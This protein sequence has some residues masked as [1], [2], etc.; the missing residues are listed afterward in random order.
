VRADLADWS[1]TAA[2]AYREWAARRG[3]TLQILA[4]A[5]ETMGLMTEAA[6][7]LIGSVRLLVRDAVATVVSRLIVYAGE[8]IATAGLAT[9]LVVEQVVTLCAAWGARIARWLRA[10][11]ASL[12]KLGEA[13]T[14]LQ[15]AVRRLQPP[16]HAEGPLHRTGD[17]IVRNGKKIL[18]TDENVAAVAAKYG[19]NTEGVKITINKSLSGGGPGREFYGFTAD[20]GKVTLTRDAFINEQQLARTLAHEHF[21]VEEIRSGMQ[22]PHSPRKLRAWESRAYA[23]ERQW[24]QD[25]KHL[26]DG[27]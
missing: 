22:V 17:G 20:D 14:G 24:W 13:M 2:T 5:S 10:L 18:M 1:G 11:I 4:R 23:Y 27:E 16:S 8:L 7:T 9:P 3:Q 15:S 25:H 26:F 21:H 12:R 6:G 19:I